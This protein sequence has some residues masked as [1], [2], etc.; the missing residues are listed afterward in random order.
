[1]SVH[2]YVR[3]KIA[4]GY[5]VK[6]ASTTVLNLVVLCCWLA[7]LAQ[8]YSCTRT[9]A[10]SIK[11]SIHSKKKLKNRNLVILIVFCIFSQR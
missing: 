8:L 10:P 6:L 5:M 11:S 7:S 1:V 9:A 4:Y 2:N 3:L